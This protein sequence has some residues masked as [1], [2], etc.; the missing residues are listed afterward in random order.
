L[1]GKT[2]REK[3]GNRGGRDGANAAGQ[4]GRKTCVPGGMGG[5]TTGLG[6]KRRESLFVKDYIPRSLVS[7]P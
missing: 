6:L 5:T 4:G 2:A 7:N 3:F 1:G